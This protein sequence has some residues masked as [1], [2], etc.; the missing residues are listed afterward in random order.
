MSVCPL[1][2]ISRFHAKQ[3]ARGLL[4]TYTGMTDAD[5]SQM[6]AAARGA[7][8]S[9]TAGL[10]QCRDVQINRNIGFLQIAV[11]AALLVTMVVLML[12]GGSSAPL[13]R[14][15]L[16]LSTTG[17][18]L[19]LVQWR[20][21]IGLVFKIGWFGFGT[22]PRV[23]ASLVGASAAATLSYTVFRRRASPRVLVALLGV[24]SATT[25]ANIYFTS[26]SV[27]RPD[28]AAM[29]AVVGALNSTFTAQ[30]ISETRQLVTG[31]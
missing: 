30:R 26:R 2:A 27:A 28:S 22:T 16:G 6:A 3:D 11:L 23:Q 4:K 25:V 24:L 29:T 13:E 19:T 5:I 15:M 10:S 18:A 31:A 1:D 21:A 8:S 14:A 7:L 12:R 17:A 20:H 9:A